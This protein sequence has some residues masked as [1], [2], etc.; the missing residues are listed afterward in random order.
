MTI[1]ITVFNFLHR[2]QNYNK[3]IE[4]SYYLINFY[5]GRKESTLI[6]ITNPT[7]KA[8]SLIKINFK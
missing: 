6:T 4:D 5:I 8:K 3:G 2:N 1:F 7:P